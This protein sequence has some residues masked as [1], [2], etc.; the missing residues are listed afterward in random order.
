MK[1]LLIFDNIDIFLINYLS[2]F[3]GDLWCCNLPI[4]DSKLKLIENEIK[5]VGVVNQDSLEKIIEYKKL[6]NLDFEVLSCLENSESKLFS[7]Y[8]GWTTYSELV[9][10]AVLK[11]YNQIYIYNLNNK[12]SDN[13]ISQLNIIT[14]KYSLSM[15]SEDKLKIIENN[16]IPKQIVV[17]KK[18][19]VLKISEKVYTNSKLEDDDFFDLKEKLHNKL[20][21]KLKYEELNFLI[22][23]ND[24]TINDINPNLDLFN[25]KLI[26]CGVNR[27]WYKI[28]PEIL[29][30]MDSLNLDEMLLSEKVFKT[31]F[32]PKFIFNNPDMPADKNLFRDLIKDNDIKLI[33]NPK[34]KLK[35]S[36]IIWLIYYLNNL[37]FREYKC[38]FYLYGVSLKIADGKHFY[39]KEESLD[40]RNISESTLQSFFNSHLDGFKWLYNANKANLISISK[41]SLLNDHIPYN[42]ISLKQ[43]LKDNKL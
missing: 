11:N 13:L 43:L 6:N 26:I 41:D 22:L 25:S 28:M 36:S 31:I 12:F 20:K 19:E 7:N 1:K 9:Q 10:E 27:I 37:L 23:G 2:N 40:K 42:T 16:N 17:N 33:N 4:N 30:F 14:K 34:I 5:S 3:D 32:M 38:N 29:F 15:L 21:K 8:S 39:N 35:K 24:K 18:I